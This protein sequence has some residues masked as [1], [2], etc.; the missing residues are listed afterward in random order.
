MILGGLG[1]NFHGFLLP[2]RL[3]RKLMSFH[4]DSGVFPDLE[5]RVGLGR[6]VLS[7]GTVSSLTGCLFVMFGIE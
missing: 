5:N 3:A 4:C 7:L 1:T 2:W 6:C